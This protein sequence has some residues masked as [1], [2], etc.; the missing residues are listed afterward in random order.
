LSAAVNL[1]FS[2]LIKRKIPGLGLGNLTASPVAVVKN[3]PLVRSETQDLQQ[4]ILRKFSTNRPAA[5]PVVS[6]VRRMYRRLGWEPTQYR[7]AAEAMIRRIWKGTGLYQINNLV[8]LANIV[9]TPV[10][11]R[12]VKIFW[13]FFT[14]RLKSKRPTSSRPWPP[15]PHCIKMSAPAVSPPPKSFAHPAVQ[16]VIINQA[17]GERPGF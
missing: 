5:D 7:P 17:A 2:D 9:S 6:A 3:S 10:S 12:T 4:F 13:L 8:D 16:T 14:S 11:R 15:W 1:S